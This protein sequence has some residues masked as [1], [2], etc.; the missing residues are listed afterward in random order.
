M[1]DKGT[2]Y[3]VRPALEALRAQAKIE[4]ILLARASGGQTQ[5][6][7]EQARQRG[8]KVV[9]V[10]REEIDRRLP[11][12]RHQGVLMIMGRDEVESVSLASVLQAAEKR[13]EAPLLLLLDGIQDPHNFGAIIRSAYA[14]GAHAVVVERNRAA[15]VSG[16]AVRASAGAA[17]QMPIVRVT[18]LKHALEEL[19]A[20]N[21][22]TAA[23]VM[24]GS[25]A[26]SARLDGPVALVIGG[27]AK[28]V[29]P[30][31]AKRCDIRVSIPLTHGFDSLNA[32]VAAGI[33]LYEIGRQRA[34]ALR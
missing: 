29:R 7:R 25:A 27:E 30:T 33:L 14:L 18:N 16:A 21:I 4:R 19:E 10:D 13:G 2:L 23:A 24:D 17:L 11:G 28:G 3:G 6:I 15:P 12:V 1:K 32:S 9:E 34:D 5:R 22:W 8:V 26:S 20:N 31:V